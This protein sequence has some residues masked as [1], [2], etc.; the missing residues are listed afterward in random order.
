MSKKINFKTRLDPDNIPQTRE[1]AAK[2]RRK[3]KEKL[4]LLTPNTLKAVAFRLRPAVLDVF[5]QMC[6][7]FNRESRIRLTKVAVL[8]LCILYARNST[9]KEL[10]DAYEENES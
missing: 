5:N 7:N 4:D 10:V 9:L 1:A 2:I 3:R 8:E 6:K